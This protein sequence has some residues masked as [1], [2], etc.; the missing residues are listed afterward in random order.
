MQPGDSLSPRCARC[1]PTAWAITYADNLPDLNMIYV[2]QTL[3]ISLV[4]NGSHLWFVPSATS[5]CHER[6]ASLEAVPKS[7]QGYAV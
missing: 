7:V 1:G 6:E 5:P 2:G 4:D 3:Y